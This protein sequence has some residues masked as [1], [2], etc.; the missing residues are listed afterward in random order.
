MLDNKT[1]SF[2]TLVFKGVYLEITTIFS[3]IICRLKFLI[4]QSKLFPGLGSS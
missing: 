1:R 3:T 4:F 2:Y